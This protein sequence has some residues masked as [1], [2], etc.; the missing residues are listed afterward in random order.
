M[1]DQTVQMGSIT[2]YVAVM[3]IVLRIEA[4]SF[5]IPKSSFTYKSFN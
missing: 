3:N 2:A 5:V 1:I 4:Y